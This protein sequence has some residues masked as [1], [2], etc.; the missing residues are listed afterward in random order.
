MKTR[1]IF[2]VILFL[3]A[4]SILSAQ[5]SFRGVVKGRVMDSA[6]G[7]PFGN[8]TVALYAMPDS[9]LKGGV[10]TDNAGEFTIQGIEEGS[11]YLIISFVGYQSE[12]FPFI[13]GTDTPETDLGDFSLRELTGDAGAVTVVAVRP[14]VTYDGDK[15]IVRVDEF[16]K[17]GASTL[18]QVLENVP[19]VTVDSEG[20]VLLRGSSGYTLLIDGKPAPSTGTNLLRQIPAEMVESIEI[21][22]NPSAKYDPDGTAGIINLILKKQKQPGFNGMLSLMAGLG[23]K[24]S[25]D[26]QFN[27]RKGKVNLFGGVTGFLYK[28]AVDGDLSRVTDLPGG[29]FLMD[30]YLTQ[31]VSIKTVN[32]N[33]GT[34]L[35]F[36]DRNSATVSG[37]F[38]PM[39]NEVGIT[40]QIFRDFRET[41]TEEYSLYKN[42]L[43]VE[44]FYY[45]P[46]ITL[47]HNFRKEGEKIQVNLLGT[48]MK[49]DIAQSLNEVATDSQWSGG[50]G[51]PNL[52]ESVLSLD[53]ADLRAKADYERPVGEKS[54]IESGFQYTIYDETNGNE[55]SNYDH[56][57]GTWVPDAT[58]TNDFAFRRDVVSA[59]TIWSSQLGKFSYQVGLRGEY[60]DRN[61]DQITLD[62]QFDYEKFSFFPSFHLTRT[63]KENQQLQLSYSRRINRPDR[64]VLNPFPQFVDNQT[65]VKGNPEVR[66]EFTGSWELNY[67]K[68]VKIGFLSAETFYRQSNDLISSVIAVDEEGSVFM[69]SG[70]SDRS[71]S[72]GGEF[73]ANMQPVNWLRFMVSGS[74]YYYLLDDESISEGADE[75]TITWN[76]NSSVVFLLS[77]NTRISFSGIYNGPSINIQGRTSGAFMLNTGVSQSFMNQRLNLSLGVRDILGSYRIKTVSRDT[78]FE[79][80]SN[81]MPEARVATLTVTYNFNNFQRRMDQQ[82]S[83]DMNF[84]R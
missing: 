25:G 38:G 11:Y 83:L 33:L 30:S 51:L 16:R 9:T 7:E 59:Y 68:Q 72:A 58:Y 42:N 14:Q 65:I 69:T 19:S 27:Y 28:T 29:Q 84:I 67:Q 47:S 36:N 10:A 13:L 24:Y 40:T 21:M 79:F 46:G 55:F 77:P 1:T 54:K 63:L 8:V 78:N 44:G 75:S 60:T 39:V 61:I 52:T 74:V 53:I 22:T 32:Y 43:T 50:I 34:D 48:G 15:K 82:E 45:N 71:H 49:G 62:E 6:T 64:N 4:F 31:D 41:G 73:M 20:N 5:L 81:I 3:S 57:G 76:T 56:N 35:T 18:A 12:M 26:A 37:R 23:D 80:S 2:L 70:N 17:A 66:P